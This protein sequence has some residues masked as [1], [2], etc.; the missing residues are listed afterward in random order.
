[1]KRLKAIAAAALAC[2]TMISF[3][4][5]SGFKVIDDEDVFFDALENAVGIDDDETYHQKNVT[6]NGDKVEYVIYAQDGDNY[7]TYI[8]FKKADDAMDLF[9]DF[10]QDF[11][12]IRDDN[13]F[14]GTNSMSATKT[15][16]SVCFNGE[17]ESG[18]TITLYRHDSYIYE[19][20]EIYGGVYVNDNVY[21]EVYSLNGSK[22][23][24]EKI[25]NFLKEIG[26]PKP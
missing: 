2:A 20:C 26:F 1:M 13:D 6:Y 8:R 9:D 18:S 14:T 10:Y 21:I 5:C 17:I 15:R 7:Y 11:Q 4:G 19:D 12:E 16:G 25:T 23:D 22:R 24:K 3:T